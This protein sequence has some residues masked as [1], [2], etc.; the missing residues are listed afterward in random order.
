MVHHTQASLKHWQIQSENSPERILGIV[1]QTGSACHG[2]IENL[3]EQSTIPM[4]LD[5][6]KII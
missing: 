2:V 4:T 1:V 6:N 5:T 3:L